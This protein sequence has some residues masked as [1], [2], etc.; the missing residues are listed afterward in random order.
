VLSTHLHEETIPLICV[1]FAESGRDLATRGLVDLVPNQNDGQQDLAISLAHLD[2]H[3][4]LVDAFELLERVLHRDGVDEH[5][6]V[7]LLYIKPL[8][9]RKLVTAGCVGDLE[10]ADYFIVRYDL[11]VGVLDGGHIGVLEC[12]ADV[13]LNE[14]ALA[15]AGCAKH[16]HPVVGARV[17]LLSARYHC[18][19]CRPGR[20]HKI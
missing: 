1:V 3:N 19:C 17:A 11:T 20:L 9:S 10:C 8:H 16:D 2:L 7:A 14:R 18:S 5:E 6:G 15:H 4:V 12:A 13:A